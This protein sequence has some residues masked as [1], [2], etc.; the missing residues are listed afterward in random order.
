MLQ[1][2]IVPAKKT[3][4]LPE[5]KD[6]GGTIA[7]GDGCQECFYCIQEARGVVNQYRLTP[8]VKLDPEIRTYVKHCCMVLI[9]KFDHIWFANFVKGGR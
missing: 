6:C 8:L 3:E 5:H 2:G 4:N 9:L 1:G 7:K